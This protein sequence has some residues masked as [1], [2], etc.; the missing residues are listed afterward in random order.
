MDATD[1]GVR[2]VCLLIAAKV[3]MS[4]IELV[5]VHRA[6]CTSCRR[7]LR[8]SHLTIGIGSMMR[9]PLK[10]VIFVLE[11]L[12]CISHRIHA[13]IVLIGPTTHN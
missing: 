5:L 4:L 9:R 2:H 8:F 10:H 3:Q 1:L 11:A 13:C 12:V 6:S 7:A